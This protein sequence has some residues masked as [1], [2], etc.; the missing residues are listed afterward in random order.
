MLHSAQ[1]VGGEH[2]RD[3]VEFPALDSDGEEEDFG[4]EIAM[5]EEEPAAMAIAEA[6]TG[7]V[8]DRWVNAGIAHDDYLDFVRAGRSP[9]PPATEPS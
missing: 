5:A 1:D 2:F 6:G 4:Q 8:P 3:L 7:P 9:H